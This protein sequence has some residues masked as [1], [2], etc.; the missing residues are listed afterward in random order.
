MVVSIDELNY[1]DCLLWLGEGKAAAEKI[2]V[3]Q[4]TLSRNARAAAS[5]LYVS[6]LK[7]DAEWYVNGDQQILR[8][9]RRLHQQIRWEKEL[10]LR[11][12]AQFYSGPFLAEGLCPRQFIVGNFDLLDTRKP[13]QLLRSGILDAWIAGYPDVPD[14][15]DETLACFRLTRLPLKLAVSVAHPL[16][17]QGDAICLDD[18]AAYPCMALPDGAFPRLEET[19]KA[20]GLWNSPVRMRRYDPAKWLGQSQDQVT[21]AYASSFSIGLFPDPM[22]FLPL[23]LGVEVGEAVVVKREFANHP[24]F[25]KLLLSLQQRSAQ[26]ARQYDDILVDF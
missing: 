15:D 11:I 6:L 16:L 3:A 21:V 25:R 20:L 4:S 1:L 8:S 18:V 19:L 9:E 7:R 17:Q 26:L 14:P 5:K 24:R 22:V 23:D 10:P 2:C 13:L 12:D